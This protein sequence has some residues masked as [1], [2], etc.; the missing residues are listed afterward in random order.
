MELVERISLYNVQC[1]CDIDFVETE[2]YVTHV[3]LAPRI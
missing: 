1:G 3:L 2:I